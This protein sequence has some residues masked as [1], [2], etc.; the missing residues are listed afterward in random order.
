VLCFGLTALYAPFLYLYFQWAP[1]DI[2]YSTFGTIS[3]PPW[4]T[5][6]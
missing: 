1:S 6:V 4:V 2:C 3:S 5:N